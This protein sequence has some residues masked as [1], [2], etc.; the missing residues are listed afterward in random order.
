MEE[1]TQIIRT[2]RFFGNNVLIDEDEVIEISDEM[3]NL[4]HSLRSSID[5]NNPTEYFDSIIEI[6][7]DCDIQWYIKRVIQ[8]EI[9]AYFELLNNSQEL[10]EHFRKQINNDQI[11]YEWYGFDVLGF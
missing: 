5:F 11:I 9:N 4:K 3:K 1:S 6:E 10:Q 2:R 7:L 8:H